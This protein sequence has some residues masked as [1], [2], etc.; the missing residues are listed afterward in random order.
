MTLRN[1]QSGSFFFFLV[2]PG[3]ESLPF[4]P[5]SPKHLSSS[6]AR[7]IIL[8]APP[9]GTPAIGKIAKAESTSFHDFN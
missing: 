7:K 4:S 3:Y 6:G 9:L 2:F 5:P 8:R 1:E